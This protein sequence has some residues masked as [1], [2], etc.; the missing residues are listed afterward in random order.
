MM[1]Q[2]KNLLLKNQI[3][4]LELAGIIVTLQANPEFT[5][6]ELY[7][8]LLFKTFNKQYEIKE[9]QEA[10]DLLLGQQIQGEITVYPD[11]HINGI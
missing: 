9:I 10:L 2:T 8:E 6:I 4:N 1:N 11:D 3:L 5:S 7:K